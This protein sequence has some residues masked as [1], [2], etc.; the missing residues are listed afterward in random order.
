MHTLP[1]ELPGE[2]KR[3]R[4]FE[5]CLFRFCSSF[6]YIN[7]YEYYV[8]DLEG[9]P[10]AVQPIGFFFSNQFSFFFVFFLK[11][12]RRDLPPLPGKREMSCSV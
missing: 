5:L 3:C 8:I 2:K 7:V 11:L 6:L 4:V 10:N 9:D 1:I 12:K